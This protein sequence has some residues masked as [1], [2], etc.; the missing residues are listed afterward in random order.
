MRRHIPR[1]RTRAFVAALLSARAAPAAD[2]PP[3]AAPPPASAATARAANRLAKEKSPYLRQ[4]AH[5]PVDWYPW[6]P[7]AFE[8]AKR[9]DKPI[10]LSV[11]YSACHWC[12]VMERESFDDPA[13]AKLIN[14]AFVPV[15]V[16]R[17]ERPDV[18]RVYMAFVT[19]TTGS[20]GWPMTVMMT[21]DGKP[22][23][24]GTYFPPEEARG[25]PGLKTLIAKASG[26]WKND[27]AKLV[28]SADGMAAGLKEI[29]TLKPADGAAAIDAA[30]LDEGARRIAVKFDKT[31]GG[32][33]IA[34]KF[35]QPP[36][37][38]FLLRQSRRTGNA[39]HRDMVLTTLRAIAAGGIHDHLGGGFHRYAV[40]A[41][42]FLP[43]FE[44][45]LYDQAQ[46]A[47]LYLD[48]YQLTRDEAF[49]RTA[50]GTLDYVLR[51]LTGEQGQFLSAE[52]ADS[53]TSAAEP[54]KKT[55]G[56]FYVWTEK[57][58][59]AELERF[60]GDALRADVFLYCY[61]VEPGG[62]VK[63][64]PHQEFG[65]RNVLF[66]AHTPAAAVEHFKLPPNQV[67]KILDESRAMLLTLRDARPRPH[68]DDKTIVAWNGLM[69]SAL[70]KAGP[71]L[72]DDRYTAAAARAAA[73]VRDNLYDA[74]TGRLLR[75]WRE[76][77]GSVEGFIDD[78]AFYVQGLL[79]LY[80]ATFDV[81]WLKLAAQ[82]AAHQD[83]KFEDADLGGYF[84]AAGGG[85]TMLMLRLKDDDE[86][87]EPSGNAVAAMNGLRLAQ[88]LDD[89]A[90][91]TRARRTLLAYVGRLKERPGSMPYLLSATGFHL[92][93]PK[94]IVIAGRPDAPDTRAM[95]RELYAHY[96][97][98]R[99]LLGADAGPGQAFLAGHAAFIKGLKPI[100]GRA[101]AYVCE[102]YACRMPTTDLA[103]LR[104]LLK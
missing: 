62:N 24:G 4:R 31:H 32:F 27:R 93:K 57:E 13:V 36:M 83:A 2:P 63:R 50:R 80:E 42:W 34:P 56:A 28:E 90:L 14:D 96:L 19:A 5:N 104:A 43:H 101:T 84:T 78:H 81:Q 88:M 59:R 38:D 6:G 91:A 68:R 17:E 51:D 33:G 97:P 79:D 54:A 40:D 44:K 35:P 71:T 41:A 30:L 21:P 74:K 67:E 95:R 1:P 12:H 61:G 76:G 26:L 37:L 86:G 98:E 64:D 3:A 7:E 66:A 39:A 29:V 49:A 99:V 22:F 75:V 100:D 11:G 9:E 23:F 94:Q 48:A 16:D 25:L 82:I 58:I 47:G 60:A 73:F 89:E 53:A 15:K 72:G 46:L 65:G 10:F 45:M 52:D 8:R 55:E 77:P 69:I 92:A 87:V 20:G 85:D 103:E 18:D 70:A 102:N